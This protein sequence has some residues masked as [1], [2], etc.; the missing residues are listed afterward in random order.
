M[1]IVI[2]ARMLYWTGVGRYTKALLEN[3]QRLDHDNEYIVITRAADRE[4]WSPQAENFRRVETN[5][6][7][8]TAGE[9]LRLAAVLR[10]LKPDLVHFT[11]TNAPIL[12]R[13]KQVVTV[14]DLTLLDHDTSRGSGVRRQVRR[15]KRIPFRQV[16]LSDAR[17]AKTLI[18][19]TDFV[20][21]QIVTRFAIP[22]AKIAVTPLAADPHLA[23]P[24]PIGE[25]GLGDQFLL[26]VGNVYPYKNAGLILDAVG[27]L[28]DRQPDLKVAITSQADYFRDQLAAQ[29]KRLEIA[30][31]I[32]FTGFVS[33]GQLVSLY[34]EAKMYVYPS[35]SEG[36][37][38]QG[39]ESMVQGLPV[40]AARG[41][42]L[43]EICGDAAEYFDP[44]NAGELAEKIDELLGDEPRRAELKKLGYR[45]SRQFSWNKMAQET[46][47]IYKAA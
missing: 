17:K 7:P 20:K 47:D 29:A 3:L 31:R 11:A 5:I 38:L 35:F 23:Q 22:A 46:L 40:L 8:Y 37:G 28:K 45:R 15:L 32:V 25:Y 19:T 34:Q 39:L 9:Q 1:R 21:R 26:F 42:S 4:L 14:H 41:T 24:E 43:E 36:F 33:D 12:Y 16:L 6:N 2:D 30:D 27:L 18:V 13:G 44:R 10:R